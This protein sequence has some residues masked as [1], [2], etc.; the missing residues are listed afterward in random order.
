MSTEPIAARMD[1]VAAGRRDAPPREAIPWTV[2]ARVAFIRVFYSTWVRVLGLSSLYR[3]GQW[4]GT[5]EYL[6]DIRRRRRVHRKLVSMFKD[7]MSARERRRIVWRYFM[8]VRCDK[9]FYTFMD[10]VPRGKL[11]NRVKLIGRE[12]IDNALARGRGTYIA[13]CHF[14]SHH[15]AGL[16]MALLGY[17]IAGVRDARESHVRRYIQQKYRDTF[18]EVS[19]MKM[20]LASSFPRGIFR[21]LA[22]NGIVASLLDVDRRRG[23]TARM[24]AAPFFGDTREFLLGPIQIALRSGA[25]TLQGFVVSR[26]DFYYQMIVLPPL[27][28]DLSDGDENERTV[29]IL[30]RYAA[31]VEQFARE[32][33]DHVM[34][35]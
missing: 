28:D 19:R 21:Q 32:H 7:G 10:R 15:V 24:H 11:M 9:I 16:M 31:N 2:V 12:N 8:R 3:F 25:P 6:T 26:R 18:P 30:R 4:F 22:D 29:A 35:I 20:Y 17:N 5:M 27:S 1:N 33:P 14:G 23:E 13:L 34:N